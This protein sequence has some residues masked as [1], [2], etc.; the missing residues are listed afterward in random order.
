MKLKHFTQ[1]SAVILA[2]CV[3]GAT[4]ARADMIVNGSFESPV[5]NGWALIANGGVPG[6]TTTDSAGLIEIDD[7]SAVGGP[8]Y[9]GVQSLEV[10]ANYPEDVQQTVTGLTAGHT[11][12]LTWAY[13]DRPGSGDEEMQVYFGGQLVTTDYDNLDGS[14][15]TLLWSENSF[16]VT[17]TG[18]SE[19]LSFDG[20]ATYPGVGDKG[21]LSYGNEVDAVSLIP[22]PE[23]SS[24]WLLGSGL[25]GMAYLLRRRVHA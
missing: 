4:H 22:T 3:F 1:I 19:V 24:L 14:N 2:F 21:G 16:L 25:A 11:Y 6:W 7:G 23:A 20:I 13:G 10:N 15:S 17:A 8:V 9:E 12:L 5:V 18:A